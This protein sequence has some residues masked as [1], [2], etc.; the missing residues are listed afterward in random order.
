MGLTK[1]LVKTIVFG[2]FVI[3][4]FLLGS[5]INRTKVNDIYRFIDTNPKYTTEIFTYTRNKLEDT[6]P[7]LLDS[8]IINSLSEEQR[9]EITEDF[10]RNQVQGVYEEGRKSVRDLYNNLQRLLSDSNS[11]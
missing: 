8:L 11:N 2:S 6:T 4:S 10:I 3:G 5:G 1:G 7:S 9:K